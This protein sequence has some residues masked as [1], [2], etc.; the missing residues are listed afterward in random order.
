LPVAQE[1]VE[2][3]SGLNGRR[4]QILK[5]LADPAITVLVV[6]H[7]DRLARFGVELVRATLEASGRR[8]LVMNE[9]ESKVDLVQD[10]T[11]VLTSLC[12]RL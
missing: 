10:M 12:A 5:V 1:I 4:K 7:R 6:E 8:L 9:T 3:G 11:D 2:I